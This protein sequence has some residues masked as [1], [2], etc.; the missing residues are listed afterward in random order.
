[1][2]A[3]TI[4][5][6]GLV[7]TSDDAGGF[8]RLDTIDGIERRIHVGPSETYGF[9]ASMSVYADLGG[10]HTGFQAEDG[11]T[12]ENA[13][14]AA[15]RRAEQ[16]MRDLHRVVAAYGSITAP[17]PSEVVASREVAS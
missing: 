17:P 2:S 5:V 11:S 15:L 6:R 10:G 7:F 3:P 9:I 1:M 12:P 13:I 14:E 4:T 8:V 16:G